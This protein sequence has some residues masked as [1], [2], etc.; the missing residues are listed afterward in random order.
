MTNTTRT[1]VAVI[2][3]GP[4]GLM[5]AELLDQAGVETVVVDNRSRE[6]IE[7]TIKAGIVEHGAAEVL[8]NSGVTPRAAMDAVRHDGI[9]FQFAGQTH[10][11]DFPDLVGKSVYLYPQHQVL[12][13]QIAKRTA[14]GRDLRFESPV[15]EIRDGETNQPKVIGTD[16]NG[17]TYEIVADFVIGADGSRSMARD[18]V[19]GSD[20]SVHHFREYPFA[21]FGILAEAP[22][23]SEELIYANSPE[24]FALIS[25]RSDTV[26]RMYL[27]CDPGQDP[28]EWSDQEVWDK[29]QACVP[30]T[31]LKR[32]PIFQ[33]DVLGFRSFVARS[34]VKGRVFL[35][36]DAAH[37]V[38]PTGAKGMNLAFGDVLILNKGLQDYFANGSTTVLDSYEERAARRVWKA[39]HYSWWM[40]T[41]LHQLPEYSSFDRNRQLGEL[42]LVTGTRAGQQYLAEGYVGW[43]YEI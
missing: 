14:E 2:G 24:G 17:E 8:V 41:M 42:S 4:A 11:F 38:P 5:L 22:K 3:A 13:D 33:R 28:N 7:G 21:W 36:G 10:R 43:D 29:L 9:E 20:H 31:E 30:N 15:T 39:E 35:A 40:T 34:F 23:S 18:F 27:Q 1:Q 26:Q 37:T 6:V 25:Q 12:I 19:N 32:G 16:K